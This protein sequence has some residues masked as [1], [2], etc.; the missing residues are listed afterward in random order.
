MEQVFIVG[1]LIAVS[2]VILK[3][4]ESMFIKK[5]HIGIK[6]LVKDALLV[7]LSSIV[8]MYAIDYIQ[9]F[10]PKAGSIQ[11]FTDSPNF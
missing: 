4:I 8:G 10:K 9:P 7:Y 5:E 3:V 1:L 6:D 2:F 11:V